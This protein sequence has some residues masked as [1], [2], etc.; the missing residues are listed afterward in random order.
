MERFPGVAFY[1]LPVP[2]HPD[3]NLR[4]TEDGNTVRRCA[5]RLSVLAKRV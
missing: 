4:V 5:R 3:A 1:A 2:P